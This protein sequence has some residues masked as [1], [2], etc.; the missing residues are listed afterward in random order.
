MIATVSLAFASRQF[1]S[2]NDGLNHPQ[3]GHFGP[4]NAVPEK[5]KD[6]KFYQHN[7]TVTLMR[8]TVEENRKLGEEIGRNA[9]AATGS[10]DSLLG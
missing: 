4:P 10:V 7:P 5:F 9:A 8:T 3:H 2:R 1:V 6:H